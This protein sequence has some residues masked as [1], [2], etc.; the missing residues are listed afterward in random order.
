[1]A[2]R[3]LA[4]SKGYVATTAVAPA[5]EP[6]RKLCSARF[7]NEPSKSFWDQA[8]LSIRFR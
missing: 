3:V 4:S 2:R 7:D 8:Y 5:R 6:G 1:M